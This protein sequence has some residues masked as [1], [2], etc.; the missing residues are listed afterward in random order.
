M[1]PVHSED[2]SGVA[3]VSGPPTQ[4]GGVFRKDDRGAILKGRAPPAYDPRKY[5][6]DVT[7]GRGK[8]LPFEVSKED[9]MPADEAGERLN[10]I[11]ELM[12]IDRENEGVIYAFDCGLF[13]CHTVNGGSVLGPGRASFAVP[14]V[15]R[16]FS[17]AEIRDFL[18]VDIRRFFRA[19]ADD[20]TEVNRKVLRELDF[21]D[22]VKSEQH[23]QLIQVASERGLSR[24]PHL[25]HDSADACMKLSP[26]ER[27][28]LS[29]SKVLVISTSNNS[30][31]RLKANNRVASADG[32]D[33]TVGV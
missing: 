9:R 8:N 25:A 24:Y 12:G 16:E 7:R 28:A 17:W 19:Y 14:G 23:A 6:Y 11:H 30:A 4:G 33:S 15:T 21:Y 13:F 2:G 31:D 3:D 20:I 26:T 32:Y 27:A 22:P 1:S 10:R 5:K 29:A 18:G